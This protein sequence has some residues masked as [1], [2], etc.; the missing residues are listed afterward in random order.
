[1]KAATLK[2]GILGVIEMP[3]KPKRFFDISNYTNDEYNDAI[4]AAPFV[5]FEEQED[6][7][8]T[9]ATIY[10]VNKGLPYSEFMD[11]QP[12]EGKIYSLPIEYRVEFKDEY[13]E[14]DLNACGWTERVAIL[15]PVK[16][17][18]KF[19][20]VEKEETQE[21]ILCCA[22]CNTPLI[23]KDHVTLNPNSELTCHS[24][25]AENWSILFEMIREGKYDLVKSKFILTRKK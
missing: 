6:A 19:K 25:W 1:M 3:E 17:E 15:T 20:G 5:P 24:C 7:I 16:E 18:G 12:E 9:L 13:H 21:K 23:G 4:K 8:N 2:N 10:A 11:W 22:Q 14:G